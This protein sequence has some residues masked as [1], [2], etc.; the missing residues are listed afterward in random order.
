MTLVP[1]DEAVERLLRNVSPVDGI[2]AIAIEDACGRVLPADLHA[3]RTQP[4]FDASAMDGYAVRAADLTGPSPVLKVVGESAAGHAFSGSLSTDEAV[5]IFT[6]A[7][8]P[9]GADAVVIQENTDRPAESKVRILERVE[10]GAHIRRAGNDFRLSDVL[11]PAASRLTPAACAL[12]ASG[13]YGT[14]EV[15]RRVRVA[16]AATGDELVPPGTPAGPSQ[17]VASN[18][19]AISMIVRVIGGSVIDLGII[20]DRRDDLASA[21]ERAQNARADILVTVGGASV[22]DHD[23]VG[24]VLTE[25]GATL[26]FWR[27]AMRPGKPLMA[28]SLGPMRILGLP[29][30]PASSLVTAELFLRPLIEKLSGAAPV[31]RRRRG[32]LGLDVKANDKRTDFLRAHI[33][34]DPAGSP[35]RV[36]PL[37]RQDSSLLSVFARADALLVRPAFAPAAVAGEPCEYVMLTTG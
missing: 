22:G 35:C 18:T 30:N 27:V 34:I 25:A 26:D 14:I 29:G 21:I 2:E 11:A 19:L 5:R 36:V 16:I 6:G 4:A 12:A 31:S 24:P 10:P 3:R 28:G 32:I 37:P 15:R 1:F 33:Q 13:G 8:V 23:L 7:P 9:D 20:P 17:T